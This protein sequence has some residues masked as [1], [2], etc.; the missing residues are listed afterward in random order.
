[1][2]VHLKDVALTRE[3]HTT[4]GE[5]TKDGWRMNC[6][7]WGHGIIPVAE[8]YAFLIQRGYTGTFAIEYAHPAGLAEQKQ[9]EAQLAAHLQPFS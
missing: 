4:G 8:I 9:H 6:C 7:L 1:M 3:K 5:Y 2:D